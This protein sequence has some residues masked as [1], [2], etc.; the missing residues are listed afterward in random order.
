M[1]TDAQ[2]VAGA[3]THDL[4]LDRLAEVAVRVGLGLAPGQELI[5]TAPVE[6]LPL[7]RRIT[8]HAYSGNRHRK[9]TQVGS[10]IN[11]PVGLPKLTLRDG[12][13]SA[14]IGTHP[15]RPESLPNQSLGSA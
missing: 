10:S 13:R 5:M 11:L 8:E 4:R 12:S 7:A 2:N 14:P 3:V 1:N 6:A 9:G 15:G